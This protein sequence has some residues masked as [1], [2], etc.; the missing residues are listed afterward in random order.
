MLQPIEMIK[1]S[2][3]VICCVVNAKQ[4]IANQDPFWSLRLGKGLLQNQ[5][6]A[7]GFLL[8]FWRVL[9]LKLIQDI[10]TILTNIPILAVKNKHTTENE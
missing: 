2:L 5:P 4:I 10:T 1:H 8:S 9:I 6:M 7:A 3:T